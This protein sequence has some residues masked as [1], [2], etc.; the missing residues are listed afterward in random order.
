MKTKLKLGVIGVGAVVREIYQYLYLR[1]RYSERLEICAVADPNQEYRDWFC[2]LAGVPANRRFSGY[3]E[4]LVKVELD[5][6][7]VNTPDHLHCGPTVDALNAGLDVVVPK[8]TAATVR[9]AHAMIQAAKKTG[10]FLGI[11]FH[12][13]EDPRIK[14]A[15]ARFQSGRYGTFQCAVFYMLD[16]L[17]VADPNHS[18]RFF[19]SPDFA[20]KNTPVSFLTVHMADALMKIVNLI[21]VQVRANGYA[22]K[23]PSLKPLAVQGYD[24]VD[25]EIQFASG[26]VAHIMTGWVLP[27][28]AHATTVQS[29]RLVCSD[30][31]VDLGLDTP[32]LR[33]LHR[34]G[35][36]EVNPLFRNFE[37]DN[38]VTGYGI[39]SPGRLYE[40]ILAAHNGNLSEAERRAAS[41]PMTLGLYTTL[42]L[43]AA[44]KSLA[45]GR[46]IDGGATL[47]S[48]VDLGQ[49]AVREL[50]EPAAKEY[51]LG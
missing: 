49:L 19:A 43:E 18:P 31:L 25:T 24:L 50:G 6:V 16:K 5:A 32:G 22:H 48:V 34:E 41:D 15:E 51:G 12:K 7:Q 40:Q 33:E 28:T 13:R 4:M 2:D 38:M 39:S 29:G 30:G 11:D 35:I 36:F 9:D 42:V 14:E 10:R 45:D 8:P 23:L 26:A 1:S 3:Q 21:P 27:N 37:K 46:R 44:E 47:G 20:A 17:L